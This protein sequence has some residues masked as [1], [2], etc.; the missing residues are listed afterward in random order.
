MER[1]IGTIYERIN[2]LKQVYCIDHDDCG[3]QHDQNPKR[4]K[5][6]Y[7]IPDFILPVILDDVIDK[8]FY[9][10]NTAEDGPPG[11]LYI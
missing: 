8:L 7:D 5:L 11:H 1:N 4:I 3:D 2:T 9:E 10:H 6:S